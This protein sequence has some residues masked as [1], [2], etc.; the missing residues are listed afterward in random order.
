MAKVEFFRSIG[1]KD[2]RDD[3]V[4][5]LPVLDLSLANRRIALFV[6]VLS[7]NCLTTHY[8]DLWQECWSPAFQQDHWS[9]PDPRLPQDFFQKLTPTWQRHC[10]LRTDYA[11]RQALVE[12]DV[13]APQAL[14]LTLDEL[15][16]IYRV[17][18]PV[19]RQYEQDTWYDA[20]GRIVFTASKGLVGVGLP[21][22][23]GKR[24]VECTVRSLEGCPT[25]RRLGWEDIQPKD[26]QPQVP[27]GTRVERPILDDTLPGGPVARTITYVAPF[28]LANR[29]ADYRLAWAH[30]QNPNQGD[31]PT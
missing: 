5:L 22:K 25:Q 6:R 31:L 14:G 16:T 8:A 11:R 21:R 29:E 26:G 28:N 30:F 17:Q 20:A 9:S 4:R 19:M 2:F 24:D 27:A 10:A 7:L 12:I 15:L 23:A 13:L 18:F 1:K 3:S